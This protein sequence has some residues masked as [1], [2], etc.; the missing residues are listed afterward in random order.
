ME[1]VKYQGEFLSKYWK[2]TK[3][4]AGKANKIITA[5]TKEECLQ[6]FSIHEPN[7]KWQHQQ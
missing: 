7:V 3:M 4:E 5:K 2:I 6:Y 1:G